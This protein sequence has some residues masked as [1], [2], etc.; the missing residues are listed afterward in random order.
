MG[1]PTADTDLFDRKELPT[2]KRS[3]VHR[4]GGCMHL[5]MHIGRMGMLMVLLASCGTPPATNSSS[6]PPP[7]A[8]PLPTSDATTT[9]TQITTRAKP[10]DTLGDVTLVTIV[11]APTQYIEGMTDACPG[12][13]VNKPG[14]Y[15]VTWLT[16]AS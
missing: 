3:L 2:M 15:T 8:A 6:P 9:S 10:G 1:L 7:S 13:E 11:P 4:L 16:G 14:V 12:N 5:L